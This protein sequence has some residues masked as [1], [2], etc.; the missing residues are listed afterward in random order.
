VTHH[1][2]LVHAVIDLSSREVA[3]ALGPDADV[4]KDA[5]LRLFRQAADIGPGPRAPEDVEPV[6]HGTGDEGLHGLDD[7]AG[8]LEGAGGI[9]DGRAGVGLELD[10]EPRLHHEADAQAPHLDAEIEPGDVG[11]R[12]AHGVARV[13]LGEFAHHQCGVHDGAGHRAGDAP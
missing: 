2:H 10:P 6:Q 1:H 8:P 13:G 7:G 3:P 4:R 12:Q 5:V 9:L 11:R